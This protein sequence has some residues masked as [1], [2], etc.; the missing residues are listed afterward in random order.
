M[1]NHLHLLLIDRQRCNIVDTVLIATV[2]N[3]IPRDNDRRF[4]FCGTTIHLR[5]EVITVLTIVNRHNRGV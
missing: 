5:K 3:R 1:P 2:I 4:G